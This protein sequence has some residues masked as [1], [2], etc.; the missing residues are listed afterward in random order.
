MTAGASAASGDLVPRLAAACLPRC[1]AWQVEAVA[2]NARLDNLDYA[3]YRVELSADRVLAMSGGRLAGQHLFL[4][5]LRIR[6]E[7]AVL[8]ALG[9]A[10]RQRGRRR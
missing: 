10:E 1:G 4:A 7:R 9:A 3:G 8:D 2:G 5:Q 6:R